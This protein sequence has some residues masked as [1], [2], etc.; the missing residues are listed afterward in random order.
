MKLWKWLTIWASLG[1][2][3]P[4]IW[5]SLFYTFGYY[6]HQNLLLITFPSSFGLMALDRPDGK[7]EIG[8]LV[9]V[10]I[11]MVVN[12]LLYVFIGCILWLL[13]VTM[14]VIRKLFVK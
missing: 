2:L 11:V 3:I 8:D 13:G 1:L 4:V 9:V 6:G 12:I 14:S 5:L 10:S 7:A